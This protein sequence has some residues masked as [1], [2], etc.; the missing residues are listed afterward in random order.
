[1]TRRGYF[2]KKSVV[3]DVWESL[4]LSCSYYEWRR[5]ETRPYVHSFML[6]DDNRRSSSTVGCFRVWY[7]E[8]A[9]ISVIL[10]SQGE[11]IFSQVSRLITLSFGEDFS[12][13]HIDP[14]WIL[15]VDTHQFVDRLEKRTKTNRCSCI[16]MSEQLDVRERIKPIRVR[17]EREDR[18]QTIIHSELNSWHSDGEYIPQQHIAFRSRRSAHC[19]RCRTLR[20]TVRFFALD[21][22]S[23]SCSPQWEI[24]RNL[25]TEERHLL[26]WSNQNACLARHRSI[27]YR[28]NLTRLCRRHER[29][30]RKTSPLDLSCRTVCRYRWICISR[31][32]HQDSH[33]RTEPIRD[34]SPWSGRNSRESHCAIRG[35]VLE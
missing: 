17:W 19:D 7:Q 12:N 10:A 16:E 15:N 27:T 22:S 13:F 34:P 18:R 5:R 9:N 31:V 23:K 33:A 25:I 21:P 30:V 24:R 6:A 2:E 4:N 11:L 20:R 32:Y 35:F 14:C 3:T 28:Y 1:M 29:H 26:I 8:F